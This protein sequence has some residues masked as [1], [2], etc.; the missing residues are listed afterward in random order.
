MAAID[1]DALLEQLD[2]L[3]AEDDADALAAARAADALAAAAGGGWAALIPAPKG[4]KGATKKTA[5]TSGAGDIAGVIAALLARDDLSEDARADLAD[6]QSAAES[7]AL[8]AQDEAYI[9]ALAA[10][11]GG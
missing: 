4:A 2:Q 1:R 8:D 11:V 5:K 10:R 9:R 6:F 7:G 3:G